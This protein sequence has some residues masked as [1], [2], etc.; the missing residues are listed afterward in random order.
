MA[1]MIPLVAPLIAACAPLTPPATATPPAV[2]LGKA[3]D[4]ANPFAKMIR[5]E[6]KPTIV[7]QD[8]TVLVFL[9][10]A[11]VSPGHALVISKTSQARNLLEM[12]DQVVAHLL[13][14]ARA[15][16]RAEIAG[17]GADGFTVE[18]N[19]VYSQSVGHLHVHVIPRYVGY[20]RCV[21]S[22]LP[23]SDA[24]LAPMAA[25]IR[26]AML[27]DKGIGMPVKPAD[28]WPAPAAAPP[29]PQVA[30]G[31]DPRPDPAAPAGMTPLQIKSHGAVMNAVLY[32]ASGAGP[33]PTLLLL[34]GFPGNEQNLDIAQAARR[35]GWNVLTLHYRGSWGSEGS[36]SFLHAMED[37]ISAIEYLRSPSAVARFGVDPRRIAVAGHSMGGMV[38]AYTVARDSGALG[39]AL[40]DAWD[41]AATRRA[42]A[43]P[44]VKKAFVEGELRG[45][46]PPLSGTS[47]S[48]LIGEIDHAP[49]ALDLIAT[50]PAIAPRPLLVIGAER[51]GAP[52]A[53]AVAQAAE[54]AGATS[55][56]L[57]VM[58]TDHSFSDKRI[59]L[60]T[61]IVDWLIKLPQ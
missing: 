2:V 33:H 12:P 20:N 41:V 5:G 31:I 40:I 57:I 10:H 59:A 7:Y 25:R 17:L 54:T 8:K 34:H 45:D 52:T 43:D 22:G 11:P 32:Q 56:Q 1:S 42:F 55:T 36:F 58:P 15:V 37:G 27:A 6:V 4:P 47:E 53:I 26:A 44:A 46:L 35:A 28:D 38:A 50:T 24:I 51:A 23:A 3:Y 13:H 19:N 18:Q 60:T 30:I 9:D 29:T 21:G 48:A 16:G 49:P 61:A 39:T 14:V